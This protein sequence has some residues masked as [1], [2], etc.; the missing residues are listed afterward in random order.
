MTLTATSY[1]AIGFVVIIAIVFIIVKCSKPKN[2][3][4]TGNVQKDY[5][6]GIPGSVKE[7]IPY[8]R[9]H[10]N[11]IIET[12]KGNY[13]KAYKI[14]DV[15]FKIAP[16]D[17]QTSIFIK[18]G[19]F[20]NSMP[21]NAKFQI[22]IENRTANFEKTFKNISFMPQND[23]LNEFRRDMNDILLEKMREGRN[24][25]TQEKILVVSITADT[26][27]AAKKEYTE[28]DK[29]IKKRFSDIS[30]EYPVEE[31]DITERLHDMYDIYNQNEEGIFFN[32]KDKRGNS[33]FD[34]NQVI[35]VGCSTK[36][37]IGPAALDFRNSGYFVMGN[38]YGKTLYL[39]NFPN[40]L[41]S[42]FLS[43]L[44]DTTFN[45]I[46]S[47]HYTPIEQAEAL[48]IV[49][50]LMLNID[51]QIAAR[52][53]KAGE[54]GYSIEL[55]SPTLIKQQKYAK[56]LID[57]MATRDQKM[58]FVTLLLTVF[59][60]TKQELDDNVR[61]VTNTAN[62][63]L[64]SFKNL[65]FQQ[66]LGLN[67]SLPLCVNEL[68]VSKM[69]TTESA[70][71]FIPYTTQELH[72]ASG[73][74]YGLNET[75][76]NMIIHNRLLGENYNGLILGESGNGKS[77]A[78]KQEMLSVLLRDPKNVVYVIDPESEYAPLCKALGGEVIDLSPNSRSYINPL[79][80][81]IDYG[82]ESDPVSMKTEFVISMIEIMIGNGREITPEEKSI[83][84]RCVQ[85][86]YRPYLDAIDSARAAGENI[87]SDKESAPTLFTLYNMIL[88]QPEA[89]A[90]GLA[91]IL[92]MYATG[93]LATFSHRT[94]VNINSRFVV[95][96]IK[97]LG[98]G[99][100]DLGIHIC[101]NDIWNRMTEN[102]KSRV[103]TWFYVDEFYLLL[104]TESSARYLSSIWKRARKRNGVPTGILQNTEDLL[105]TDDSRAI[106]NNSSF[107]QMFSLKK[108]DRMN[109]K[110]LLG[111][112]EA[113]LQNITDAGPGRGLLYASKTIL[114]FDNQFP[115]DTELYKIMSTSAT[116][117]ERR[118]MK[119]VES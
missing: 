12:R 105:R 73:I 76:K 101:L 65:F 110:S 113:Q 107:I 40:W 81:D 42:E 54:G 99:T 47:I 14:H 21:V 13:T 95:Y 85:Q 45:M 68:H 35:N 41:S 24:N 102:E 84:S 57:D 32:A 11:N 15:N 20:L 93:T 94:N 118:R 114:P 74:Y 92:E 51:G 16:D 80:M 55:V 22:L 43:D 2:N 112:S 111:V 96:D 48:R 83:V 7:S 66:E 90:K 28:I 56:D 97:N 17:E 44:S 89:S 115:E 4:K 116:K 18:F 82:D 77:F 50:S 100:K 53:K 79:D 34:A 30:R 37:V 25:I 1:L 86:I 19:R 78:A 46:T 31:I 106:L 63:Y 103:Y 71:I 67:A 36:D 8:I 52:Q 58:F 10:D 60:R 104:Q 3:A 109:I 49:H 5:K 117:D 75:S 108:I 27:E 61:T 88:A 91:A 26:L 59:G 70:A 9:I 6:K 87:T 62:N 98:T 23:D 38:T 64:C 69:L 33:V 39:D 72:Q 119:F 29:V